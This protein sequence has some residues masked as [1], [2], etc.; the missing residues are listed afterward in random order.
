MLHS[1]MPVLIKSKDCGLAHRYLHPSHLVPHPGSSK[2]HTVVST[3][4]TMLLEIE[5][6]LRAID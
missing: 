6:E 4:V 2:T 5:D 1:T 3:T